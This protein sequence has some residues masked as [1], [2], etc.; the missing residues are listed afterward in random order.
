MDVEAFEEAAMM[1]R[2]AVEPAA[3]RAAMDLYSGELLPEDRY[4]AWAQDRRAELRGEYLSLLV[5][6]AGLYEQRREF[7]AAIEALSRVVAEEPAHQESLVRLM[8]LYALSGRRR[9]ALNAWC[10]LADEL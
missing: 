8:R 5:E 6:L 2:H 1:A 7:E 3:F 9:E 10:E 4:E